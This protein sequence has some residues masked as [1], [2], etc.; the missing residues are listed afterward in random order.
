MKGIIKMMCW[1]TALF[2]LANVAVFGQKTTAED[3]D[4]SKKQ[5]ILRGTSEADLMI[6]VGDIDNMNFGWGD[7]FDPFSG[8]PTDVHAFPWW[9]DD[10]EPQGTDRIFAP[11]SFIRSR[12]GLTENFSDCGGDGYSDAAIAPQKISLPLGEIKKNMQIKTATL[13]IFID[14]F[15][16]P[17]KCSDFKVWLNGKE[18]FTQ[19]EE[20]LKRVE[21][22][23]PIGK[24]VTIPLTKSQLQLLSAPEL[25]IF[26]DD[27][28]SF[29]ADGF[30]I[31]FVKLLVNVSDKQAA[32]NAK[33][34]ILAADTR[35]PIEGASF[36]VLS[37]SK[38]YKTNVK[39][40]A[41]MNNLLV[42]LQAAT[43]SAKGY[44]SQDVSFDIYAGQTQTLTTIYLE[45]GKTNF[46]IGDKF[47]L[48]NVQFE[49]AK[50][51]LLP[52]GKA[53][54]DLL[55]DYLRKNESAQIDLSGFTSD[56]GDYKNNVILSKQR[57]EACKTYLVAAGIAENRIDVYGFGPAKPLAPNT[58]PA[59]RAKNRR[60][61]LAIRRAKK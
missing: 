8:Q 41:V 51:D 48:Q 47:V 61:E 32:G 16:S 25:T 42:G 26:I 21:Q 50:Y 20:L 35:L 1:Q 6:R 18:R 12:D 39:G 33:V 15:Q 44:I 46:D 45:K 57:A 5:E 14:D 58:T 36:E 56:E 22:G 38:A 19:L 30:A 55:V 59:Y 7:G 27:S 2:L 43:A 9:A 37:L 40:E 49:R 60:V 34:L 11:S 10:S 28:T 53:E 23:G 17:T 31:D 4:W 13:Q 54:L 3:G 24:L 52:E 29:A